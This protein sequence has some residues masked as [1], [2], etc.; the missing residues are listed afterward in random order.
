MIVKVLGTGCPSCKK[1]EN[2]TQEAIKELKIDAKIEKIEDIQK[3]MSYGIMSVPAL[4]VDE[5][6]VSAGQVLDRE[7]IKKLLTKKDGKG[8]KDNK[9]NGYS[10]SDGDCC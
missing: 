4:M 2:N 3:I 10:C 6:V 9:S 5:K 1:L 7:E 8:S